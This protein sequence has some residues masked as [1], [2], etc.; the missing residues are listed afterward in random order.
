MIAGFFSLFSSFLLLISPY[1]CRRPFSCRHFFP[2]HPSTDTF[3]PG[4]WAMCIPVLDTSKKRMKLPSPRTSR[5]PQGDLLWDDVLVTSNG[6]MS[7]L[8]SSLGGSWSGGCV[9]IPG[10][11]STFLCWGFAAEV[12]RIHFRWSEYPKDIRPITHC[13][14]EKLYCSSENE[15]YQ[16]SSSWPS[17]AR[18]E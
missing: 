4:S 1:P 6:C 17:T 8:A 2:N 16:S 5:C 11:Q 12:T 18:E 15:S 10:D 9:N 3:C 14:L 13:L 7:S